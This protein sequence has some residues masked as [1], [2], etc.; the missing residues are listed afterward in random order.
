MKIKYFGWVVALAFVF[1]QLSIPGT[2]IALE[3]WLAT[4]SSQCSSDLVTHPCYFTLLDAVTQSLD[5]DSIR[6]RPGSYP[7]NVTLNKSVTIFGEETARTILNGSGT[8]AILTISNVATSMIV[9]NI[10]FVTAATG[11]Q[12]SNSPTVTISN[13][14]FAGA[15]I[16]VQTIASSSSTVINNTFNNNVT[17]ISSD[18]TTLNITNNIFLQNSGGT[19]IAPNTMSL[20][21]IKSNLFFGGA[22]GPP[23]VTVTTSPISSDPNF[24]NPSWKGNI[25]NLNPLLVDPNDN[26]I[27]KRDFHLQVDSPA[28]NNG[29]SSGGL[30]KAG[31]TSQTD[32]GA[33]GGSNSDTIPFFV[34]GLVVTSVT[35]TSP[36]TAS[37]Q[38]TPNTCYLVSG[39]FVYFG[40]A[41]G[42][43]GTPI[44]TLST[45][46]TFS[47][48][49]LVST[50][51]STPIG[52][53]VVSDTISS[54]TINLAW[55]STGAIGYEIRYDTITP[56]TPPP[57]TPPASTVVI[58]TSTTS[59]S[60]GGLVNGTTYYF[61][62][63]PFDQTIYYIAVKAHY[64]DNTLISSVFSN[65]AQAFLN[66]KIYG[67]PSAE[68]H[69][70]PE[71]VVAN[72]DLPNTGCF[73]ATAAYGHYSAPQVQALREFRDRYLM[74]NSAGQA[75]VAWYYRYGPIGA[76]YLNAHEWLKP[77]VRTALL[78]AVGGAL[79]MTR[80]SLLTKAAVLILTGG[81][82]GCLLIY[83][84]KLV[85]SGG[86]R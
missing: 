56:V 6:I 60:I 33:Y 7:A 54:N 11:I 86:P 10:T 15:T 43:Y 47:I 3:R 67:T 65:E 39:Y 51:T 66:D 68:F 13:N 85:R 81:L 73:I 21:G 17:G 61:I 74:T 84:R 12:L 31:D 77:V 26:D 27:T 19:A 14:V 36:A 20:L 75:F 9:R 37:I 57:A 63:T 32:I 16:A 58:D 69:D 55:S 53:P 35:G 52:T 8:G 40:T 18:S 29:D 82:L 23:V 79:F 48:P 2:T 62:V 80:T 4:N 28:I 30:N 25:S 46:S 45:A 59:L 76:G 64:V 44:D 70:F 41:S 34:S 42:T 72:P 78:P 71:A 49:D 38:W 1:L 24:T 50:V 5:G 22:I 83:R